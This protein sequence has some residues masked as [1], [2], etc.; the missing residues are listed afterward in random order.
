MVLLTAVQSDK[1]PSP[2]LCYLGGVLVGDECFIEYVYYVTKTVRMLRSIAKTSKTKMRPI[3]AVD[4]HCKQRANALIELLMW[5]Q[6]LV[7]A[8]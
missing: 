7:I 3:R 6:N 5:R 2:F 4:K 1:T 8:M